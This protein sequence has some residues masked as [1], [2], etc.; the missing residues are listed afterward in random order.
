M[1]AD[2]PAAITSRR[3]RVLCLISTVIDDIVH[4]ATQG[5]A[6]V[7]AE[8]TVWLS[9][10]AEKRQNEGAAD[11]GAAT[12]AVRQGSVWIEG[13]IDLLLAE[14]Y[15]VT[16]TGDHGHVE[17]VGIGNPQEGVLASTRSKRARLYSSLDLAQ[18][19]ATQLP[20]TMIID[21][22]WLRPQ[23]V[24][25]VVALRR[26]AYALQ[27]ERVVTHGGLTVEEMIVPLITLTRQVQE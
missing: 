17:A 14:G 2:Y 9:P 22:G 10:N 25:P 11:L 23:G 27:S 15:T 26:S 5:A 6:G 4:G 18:N 21:T 19:A 7:Y 13:L 8:L 24:F 12:G 3:T 20:D 1:G 16:I